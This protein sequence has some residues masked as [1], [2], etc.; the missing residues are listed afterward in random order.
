M[1]C[2]IIVVVV[3]AI[4]PFSLVYFSSGLAF[5]PHIFIYCCALLIVVQYKRI[6]YLLFCSFI[7]SLVHPIWFFQSFQSFLHEIA[8]RTLH[9]REQK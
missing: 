4:V 9:A 7:F 2:F 1:L 3:L 5:I 6:S 8:K